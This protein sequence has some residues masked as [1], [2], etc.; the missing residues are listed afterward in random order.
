MAEQKT[1]QKENVFLKDDL[2]K[3]KRFSKYV[4]LLNALLEDGKQYSINGTQKI[5]DGFLK[6][7]VK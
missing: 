5:I 6:G 2:L 7:E 1:R 4:D 3:S